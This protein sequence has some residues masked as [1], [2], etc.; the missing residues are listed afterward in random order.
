MR[1][2]PVFPE[3]RTK[4]ND[5]LFFERVND[6]VR[7]FHEDL[8]IFEHD[9]S[10]IP[11]YHLIMSQL[12]VNGNAKQ[13]ELCRAFQVVPLRIKRAV[14]L[15]REK[16]PSGFYEERRKRGPHVLTPDVLERA[17]LLLDDHQEIGVVARQVGVKY[18]TLRKA[19]KAGK[20]HQPLKKNA[21][22]LSLSRN[23]K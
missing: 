6:T 13:S 23:Q 1:H 3:G 15:Y 7:Y 5:R 10:D 4:I 2:P 21:L 16:G 18:D 12:Y 14:S 9:S 11:T 8:P 22:P 19:V 20:L 17:Q